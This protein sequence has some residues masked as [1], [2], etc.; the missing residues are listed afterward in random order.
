MFGTYMMAG[1][2]PGG[3]PPFEVYVSANSD[4]ADNELA[5]D[6]GYEFPVIA[7]VNEEE[8]ETYVTFYKD[9]DLAAVSSYTICFAWALSDNGSR[10]SV[11]KYNLYALYADGFLTFTTYLYR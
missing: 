11:L 10:F 4:G 3:D 5:F 6:F 1:T 7:A 8:G 2:N 9:H